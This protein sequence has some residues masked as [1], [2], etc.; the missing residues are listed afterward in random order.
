MFD[1]PALYFAIGLKSTVM[2]LGSTRRHY[3]RTRIRHMEVNESNELGCLMVD[4]EI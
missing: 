4:Q 1:T 3:F 2:A